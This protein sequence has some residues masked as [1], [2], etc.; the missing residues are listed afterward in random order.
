LKI[1]KEKHQIETIDSEEIYKNINRTLEEEQKRLNK[2]TD[3]LLSEL[4]SEADFKTKKN[5][6][7]NTITNLQ[8]QRDNT[9]GRS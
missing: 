4:I 3:M 2:L 1:L 8:S 5:E 6:I 9:E 7:N